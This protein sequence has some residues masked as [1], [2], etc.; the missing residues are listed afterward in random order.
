MCS[1]GTRYGETRE[2]VF[3]PLFRSV[4]LDVN[5]QRL[6]SSLY[7]DGLQLVRVPLE[8]AAPDAQL[9]ESLGPM[10]EE[11]RMRC[12][13]RSPPERPPDPP[14]SYGALSAGVTAVRAEFQV[15]TC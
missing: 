4:P 2:E 7:G 15:E 6:Q 9:V 14:R 5:V 1:T 12:G 13:G 3:R 8:S 10:W 11:E